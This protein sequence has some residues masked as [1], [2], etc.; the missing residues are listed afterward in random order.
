MSCLNTTGCSGNENFTRL[1]DRAGKNRFLQ[2]A[3]RFSSEITGIGP[4]ESFYRGM[5]EALGYSGNKDAF[6]ELAR[7]APLEYLEM[8]KDCGM[9]DEKYI[10]Y[11]QLIL[12]GTA[13]FLTVENMERLLS[14]GLDKVLVR[15]MIGKVKSIDLKNAMSPGNWR[16]FRIRPCNSPVR[17]LV[18][19][20]YLLLKYRRK[21]LLRGALDLINSVSDITKPRNQEKELVVSAGGTSYLGDTRAAEIIVN[22]LL[23]FTF[24]YGKHNDESELSGKALALYTNYPGLEMNSLLRHMTTQFGFSKKAVNT[25]IRQQGMIHIYKNLCTRG[26]CAD[27][28]LGKLESGR[29]IQGQPV[30]L[31]GLEPEEAAGG[32][33]RGIIGA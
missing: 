21:G 18:A 23:P 5:M 11:L 25:T 10:F 24:A 15:Q 33:H 16:F 4:G 31:S 29:N 14:A 3:E 26:R 1:L 2:K 7:R 17:R 19:M 13:G 22:V 8:K 6:M 27:C 28:E 32:D 9:P 30:N 20:C 12:L